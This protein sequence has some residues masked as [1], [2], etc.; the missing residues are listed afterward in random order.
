MGPKWGWRRARKRWSREFDDF[1][2]ESVEGRDRTMEA[3]N[4][5]L[6]RCGGGW[7]FRI[8]TDRDLKHHKMRRSLG[9]VSIVRIVFLSLSVSKNRSQKLINRSYLNNRVCLCICI[10]LFIYICIHVVYNKCWLTESL[11][12]LYITESL[13]FFFFFLTGFEDSQAYWCARV[14]RDDLQI[15]TA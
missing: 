13:L 5:V 4:W 8:S 9:M 12:T 7:D 15:L 1:E 14:F 3:E 10:C 6:C 11:W 2:K